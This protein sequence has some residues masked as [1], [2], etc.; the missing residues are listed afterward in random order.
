MPIYEFKCKD[1]DNKFELLCSMGGGG[2]ASCPDCGS[3][4]VSRLLST[5]FSRSVGSDGSSHSHGGS[6]ANCSTGA[7]STCACH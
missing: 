6:C 5:F 1:C 7:C 3:G 4:E 2:D